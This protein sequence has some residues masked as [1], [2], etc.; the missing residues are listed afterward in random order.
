MIHNDTLYGLMR[1]DL[2]HPTREDVA[3]G[4]AVLHVQKCGWR[5]ILSRGDHAAGEA[6]WPLR[7]PAASAGGLIDVRNCGRLCT[8]QARLGRASRPVT[9]ATWWRARRTAASSVP[10]AGRVSWMSTRSSRPSKG[11]ASS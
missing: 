9:G 3:P 11:N 5:G 2:E 10:G 8:V 4:M 6:S 7:R 1:P